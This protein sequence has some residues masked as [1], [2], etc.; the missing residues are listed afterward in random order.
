MFD[1]VSFFLFFFGSPHMSI[2]PRELFLAMCKRVEGQNT[3]HHEA[4]ENGKNKDEL[5]SFEATARFGF[6]R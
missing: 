4:K 3:R 2:L 1:P 6:A 5:A